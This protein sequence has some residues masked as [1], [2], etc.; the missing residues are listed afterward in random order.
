[1]SDFDSKAALPHE[2]ISFL[3]AHSVGIC[4]SSLSENAFTYKQATLQAS[5]TQNNNMRASWYHS[6]EFFFLSLTVQL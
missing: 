4:S 1:M 5:L 6:F 2:L 3:L